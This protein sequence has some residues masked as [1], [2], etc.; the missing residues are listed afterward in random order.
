MKASDLLKV[1]K[2]RK[3]S[4]VDRSQ[5]LAHLHALLIHRT[6]RAKS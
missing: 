3:C 1:R 2:H 5:L 4:D 6:L